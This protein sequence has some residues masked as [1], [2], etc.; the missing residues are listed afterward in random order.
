MRRAPRRTPIQEPDE[1]NGPFGTS[2]A[3][4]EEGKFHEVVR[5]DGTNRDTGLAGQAAIEA[6]PASR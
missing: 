1:R 2:S 5:A 6:S 4:R 3:L